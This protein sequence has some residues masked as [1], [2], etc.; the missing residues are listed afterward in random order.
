[1]CL[2]MWLFEFNVFRIH[3]VSKILKI[4]VIHQIWDV[5]NHQFKYPLHFYLS[6]NAYVGPLYDV[7]ESLGFVPFLLFSFLSSDSVISYLQIYCFFFCLLQS[8]V[9]HQ[10]IFLF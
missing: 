9:K 3:W 8:A 10:W 5:S 1:M 6:N 4:Y 2:N 7:S